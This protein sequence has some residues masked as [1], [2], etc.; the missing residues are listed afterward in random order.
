MRRMGVDSRKWVI[1]GCHWEE[2][3]VN[4]EKGEGVEG[5]EVG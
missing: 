2:G 1:S 5:Q 4:R 3:E